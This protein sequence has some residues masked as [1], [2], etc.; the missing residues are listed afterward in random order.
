MD[1]ALI[2][3][4]QGHPFFPVL[5]IEVVV[6]TTFHASSSSVESW[7]NYHRQGDLALDIWHWPIGQSQ[8]LSQHPALFCSLWL[9]RC[10]GGVNSLISWVENLTSWKLEGEGVNSLLPPL[11]GT[12]C[13]LWRTC[14]F[15]P[16]KAQ[17]L[18]SA[19]ALCVQKQD[20]ATKWQCPA[21]TRCF[22]ALCSLLLVGSSL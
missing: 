18:R 14:R 8:S 15:A 3:L 6:M 7:P 19:W 17:K 16:G 5:F 22:W 13:L 10:W 1:T 2:F 20:M 11:L 12:S 4:K 21:R 9:Y